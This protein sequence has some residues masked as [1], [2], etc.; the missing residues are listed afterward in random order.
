MGYTR[1][2]GL[3]EPSR[4]EIDAI[5]GSLVLE[6]G[7]PWCGYCREMQP[8]LESLLAQHPELR[9]I[10]IEDGRGRRLGRTFTVKLWPTL[11]FLKNGRE[12]ARAVRPHSLTDLRNGLDA[13]LAPEVTE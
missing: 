2:Y 3:Q 7:A 12:M 1:E 5:D 11:I 8:M 4:S 10:K 13:L 6:F 9:H